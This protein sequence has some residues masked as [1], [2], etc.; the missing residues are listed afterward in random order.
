VISLDIAVAFRREG[1]EVVAVVEPEDFGAVG[2]FYEDFHQLSDDEVVG[3]LRLTAG[4][5]ATP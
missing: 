1:F 3:L 2:Q 5:A 4:V